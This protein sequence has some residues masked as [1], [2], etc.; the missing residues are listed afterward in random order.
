MLEYVDVGHLVIL[1]YIQFTFPFL[2]PY[3]QQQP[4]AL[5]KKEQETTLVGSA[6]HLVY[7]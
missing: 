4:Q 5:A 1:S 7:Y 6:Y 3:A 2:L